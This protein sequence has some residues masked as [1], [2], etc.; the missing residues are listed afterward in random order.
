VAVSTYDRM[1]VGDRVESPSRSLDADTVAE[2]VALGGYT[3]P[4]FTDAAFAA[5][6]PMGRSPVPGEALLLLMGGLMEQTGVFDE[7]TI[8]LTG[9]DGVRFAAPAFAGDTVQVE[10]EVVGKEPSPS[11]RRGTLVFLWRCTTTAGHVLVEATAR[12]LFRTA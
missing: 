5:T 2:L 7:T 9:F 6:T 1:S 11:G 10:A 3:H 12:M 8:A 4:L